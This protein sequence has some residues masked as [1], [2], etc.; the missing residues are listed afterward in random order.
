MIISTRQGRADPDRNVIKFVGYK[1]KYWVSKPQGHHQSHCGSF[2]GEGPSVHT[3]RQK[4]SGARKKKNITEEYKG[5][6]SARSL[7]QNKYFLF[8]LNS[9]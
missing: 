5:E 9:L 3:S 7:A 1:Q 2:S 6:K 4:Y 8:S